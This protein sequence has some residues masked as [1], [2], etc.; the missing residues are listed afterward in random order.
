MTKRELYDHERKWA[1]SS[2][3]KTR[4]LGGVKLRIDKSLVTLIVYRVT[5]PWMERSTRY[6]KRVATRY[7]LAIDERVVTSGVVS[8]SKWK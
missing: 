5:S 6:R 4:F 8:K 1:C 7:A 3:D 2:R